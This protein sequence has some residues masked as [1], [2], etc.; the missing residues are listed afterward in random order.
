MSTIDRILATIDAA[1]DAGEVRWDEHDVL[2][3]A[4]DALDALR[5]QADATAAAFNA[6]FGTGE[7][8]WAD[9]DTIIVHAPDS[10]E[11]WA[12]REQ[13]AQVVR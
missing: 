2:V 12:I 7:I 1:F 5:V 3:P 6:R 4:L 11:A 10:P 9:D 8:E 13:A